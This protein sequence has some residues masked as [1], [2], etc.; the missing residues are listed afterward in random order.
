MINGACRHVV[1]GRMERAEMHWTLPSA[2]APLN[3][4]C[5]AINDDWEPCMNHH[6][7][8]EIARL[9]ANIP[10]QPPSTRLRLVA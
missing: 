4:R 2:Q 6:I 7:Q 9:Y 3:L 5:V 8:H 10:I 1:K